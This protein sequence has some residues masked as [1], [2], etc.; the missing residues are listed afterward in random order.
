MVLGRTDVDVPFRHLGPRRLP[1]EDAVDDGEVLEELGVVRAAKLVVEVV[2]VRYEERLNA[3]V[4]KH[5]DE[6]G[7]PSLVGRALTE[8][9]V[10]AIERADEWAVLVQVVGGAALVLQQEGDEGRR[11]VERGHVE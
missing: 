1:A 5:V 3:R 4:R 6:L 11:V 8:G 9:H 2:K 7:L 10:P